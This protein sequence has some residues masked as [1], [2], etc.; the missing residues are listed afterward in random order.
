VIWRV[1][2]AVVDLLSSSWCYGPYRWLVSRWKVREIVDWVVMTIH[3]LAM[4]EIV[5]SGV[6][7][8][9]E[10]VGEGVAWMAREGSGEGKPGRR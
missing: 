9:S 8:R 4:A 5:G 6:L 7:A 3:V 10:E 1:W 2:V